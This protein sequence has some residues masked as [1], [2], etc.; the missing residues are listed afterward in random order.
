M[1]SGKNFESAIYEGFVRHRRHY[2]S[3]REFR[4]PIFMFLLNTE[5]IPKV[6][7]SFWQLGTR[8]LSWA[9]FRREDYL[10]RHDGNLS[11]SVKSKIAELLG[12]K[13]RQLDGDVYVLCH[14]RYFGFYFSPL[15]IYF[16][17]ENSKFKYVLAEVSNT[18]WNEKHYYL[19]DPDDL[20]PHQKAFHVSPFIPMDQTYRWMIKPP[21]SNS[22]R[23]VIHIESTQN[24]N[25]TKVFDATLSLKRKP[26][27]QRE[28]SRVLLKTPI[29]TASI[30]MGIY[31]QA[32]KLFL[33][34]TPFYGHPTK[35]KIKIEKGTL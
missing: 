19:L 27:I 7:Q 35:N 28:L 1:S 13:D 26:L 6:L 14:L 3:K 23:C 4:Y 12:N 25:D 18:P 21:F 10:G 20:A 33:K 22:E 29:Q 32:L 2:P 24:S 30:V 11:L 31:W 15:N 16:L 17:K 5:E 8:V 34:R 9:R